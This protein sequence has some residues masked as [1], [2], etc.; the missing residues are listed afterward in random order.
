MTSWKKPT[1]ELLAKAEAQLTQGQFYR[2][3][4]EGL[5][6][7]EWIVPLRDK[8]WFNSPSQVERDTERG[9]IGFRTWAASE[10]LV[11]MAEHAPEIV[12]ET[13]LGIPESDNFSVHEDFLEAAAKLP[14]ALA[15]KIADKEAKWIAKQPVMFTLLPTKLGRL[16]VHLAKLGEKKAALQLVQALLIITFKPEST[17]RY[18]DRVQAKIDAWHYRDFLKKFLPELSPALGLPLIENRAVTLNVYMLETNKKQAESGDDHSYIWR[19][20]IEQHSQN[21]SSRIE[22]ALVVGCRDS[23]ELAIQAGT[24]QLEEVLAA[25]GRYKWWLFRRLELHLVR[26][27]G[28][29]NQVNAFAARKEL[30]EE[31]GVR[32]EYAGLL[33]GRAADLTEATVEAFGSWLETGPDYARWQKNMEEGDGKKPTPAEVTLFGERWKRGQLAFFRDRIP[34]TLAKKYEAVIARHPEPEHVDFPSYVSAGWVVKES[35]KTADELKAL[36]DADLVA[37]LRSWSPEPKRGFDQDTRSGLAQT[38]AEAAKS[39][40]RRFAGM[41]DTFVGLDPTYIRCVL[42]TFEEATRKDLK[43]DLNKLLGLCEWVIAQ[44]GALP[45]P[46]NRDEDPDWSWVRKGAVSFLKATLEK[47]CFDLTARERV[48]VVISAVTKDSDPTPEDES[49]EKESNSTEPEIISLNTARGQAMHAV[50]QYGLWVRRQFDKREEKARAARGFLEMPEVKAVL[51]EHLD[52]AKDSSPGIRSVYGQWF[53]WLLLLDPAWATA[54]AAQIFPTATQTDRLRKTAWLTYLCFCHPYDNVFRA[55][56]PHYAA[57]IGRL[58]EDAEMKSRH[59]DPDER[60]GHHLVTFYWRGLLSLDTTALLYKY[61]DAATDKMRASVVEH[62]GR[63]LNNTKGKPPKKYL[64][65]MQSF[66]DW[67][68]T[69]GPLAATLGVETAAAF[70]WWFCSEKLPLDWTLPRLVKAVEHGKDVE[71]SQ[72]HV[73]EQLTKLAAS[74]PLE[75]V[76]IFD[77]LARNDKEGWNVSHWEKEAWGALERALNSDDAK[78]KKIATDLIDFLGKRGYL[79]FG[80]LLPGRRS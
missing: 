38:L 6:N 20:A 3:F 79:R 18:R 47:N 7:P 69:T 67:L 34:G 33:H 36:S 11:R 25:F 71:P 32:H 44:S 72:H 10:Y 9:T 59:G 54:T 22:D 1:P 28:T 49:E 8:G 17:E 62:V 29:K 26:K 77:V 45:A 12:T 50:V 57:A 15:V 27:L 37:F 42:Q 66:W 63:S 55:L 60:L 43:E 76:Q 78:A 31:T 30:F 56:E 48:W 53:P 4:F 21:G 75:P 52:P 73:A 40:P 19:P 46:R 64:E 39:D 68:A 70:G 74:H 23:A 14:A 5:K 24:V 65:R 16:A 35:P 51:E 61:L 13:I 41:A 58:G 2:R 80:E